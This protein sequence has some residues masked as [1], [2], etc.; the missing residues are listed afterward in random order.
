[1]IEVPE[2]KKLAK[3]AGFYA[4][5]I[6]VVGSIVLRNDTEDIGISHDA[7]TI[8]FKDKK[9]ENLVKWLRAMILSKR[10]LSLVD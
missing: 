3:E 6:P 1:M 10:I 7:R 8:I 5:Y 9:K 2:I 4:S